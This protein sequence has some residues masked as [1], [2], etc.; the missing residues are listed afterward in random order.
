M[1]MTPPTSPLR[2]LN[3]DGNKVLSTFNTLGVFTDLAINHSEL[4]KL[5]VDE[6]VTRVLMAVEFGTAKAFL[7][8]YQRPVG[9]ASW[10]HVSESK[11]Q[12]L[13]SGN[14]TGVT[15]PKFFFCDDAEEKKHLWFVDLINPFSSPLFMYRA[16]REEFNQYENAYILQPQNKKYRLRKIW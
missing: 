1:L 5:N 4:N 2:P 9:Y 10:A 6:T 3:L 7:D 16:L 12:W 15:D 8:D 13:L 11:H 14:A